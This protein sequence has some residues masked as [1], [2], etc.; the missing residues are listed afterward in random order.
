[1][2]INTKL[3][4]LCSGV[5]IAA[6]VIGCEDVIKI[7]LKSVEPRLVIEGVISDQPGQSGFA[8]SKTTNFF[9]PSVFP[10]ISGALVIVT[11]DN[12]QTDTLPE[13]QPGIYASDNLIGEIGRIYHA[14]VTV[15][16]ITYSATS[17][18]P[19]PIT[20]DS[21]KME[22]QE[23]GGFGSEEDEGYR[24]HV[25]F[26]DPPDVPD[27][28]RIRITVNDS[29]LPD[30][31]L[32][33]DDFTDGNSIDYNYFT[34]V[35]QENDTLIVEYISMDSTVYDYFRTMAAVV[36]SEEGGEDPV[37]PANP[38]TNWNHDALGYFGA[39]SVNPE[40]LIVLGNR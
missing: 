10:M 33:D 27:F 13:I 23:G 28:G 37:A 19:D 6:F 35:F 21:I 16:S 40:T 22:Y 4:I 39:F 32:Y 7:D 15:D 1:M 3:I 14:S 9:E 11:D 38:L 12:G 25:Y 36:A 29:L 20:V 26:S 5:I 2:R 24:L 31:F 18:I 8:I 30:Y 17:Y 34:Q